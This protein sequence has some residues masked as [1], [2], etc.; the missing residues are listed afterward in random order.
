MAASRTR[1][2][3][4]SRPRRS[5]RPRAAGS[6]ANGRGQK[7][8]LLIG[9]HAR[10]VFA[11]RV[12]LQHRL[13]PGLKA[14]L[15][16]LRRHARL[17]T[18]EDVQPTTTP[19][20][21][22]VELRRG[23]A[24]HHGGNPHRWNRAPV[25]AAETRVRHADDRHR[26]RVDEDRAADNVASAAETVL[27]VVERQHDDRMRAGLLVVGFLDGPSEQRTYAKHAEV[28]ARDNLGADRFGRVLEREVDAGRRPPEHPVEHLVL[29]AQILVE[30]IRHQVVAAPAVADERPAPVQQDEPIG[31]PHRQQSKERLIHERE[32]GR[33]RADPQ[34]DRQQR[35]DREAF[36]PEKTAPA[37][38]HV[39][40]QV[41]Q[42]V[43]SWTA[44]GEKGLR[45]VLRS[46]FLVLRSSFLV[47][48]PSF[49]VLRSSFLHHQSNYAGDHQRSGPH[50][51]D[52]E[53]G[54]A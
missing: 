7:T 21:Q 38:P 20:Q 13:E 50:Q 47:L 23:L 12:G 14:G 22:P 46:S 11:P 15:G 40:P 19:I 28:R 18:A 27:P 51:V 8:T 42:H 31:L 5:D 26:V 53:P 3:R 39:P 1:S 45:N 33:V 10:P 37:Q 16:L 54:L 9:R 2:G 6:S 41:R 25:D 35:G 4:S 30:G 29:V 34:A 32:Y 48:R 24:F 36:V 44:S 17:Q 43:V 49:F 52:V